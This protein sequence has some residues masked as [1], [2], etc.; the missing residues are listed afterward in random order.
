MN[1]KTKL[2]LS[3]GLLFAMIL[4]LSV[5]ASKYVY[6]LK[7]DTVNILANN[8]NSLEYARNMLTALDE[9]QGDPQA[10]KRFENELAKQKNNV[11]E[12]GEPL[13]TQ[14]VYDHFQKLKADSSDSEL[15]PLIRK[16]ISE[17]IR[18]NMYAINAKSDK[19]LHTVGE[20]I[21]LIVMTGTICFVL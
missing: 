4:M 21:L 15:Y 3:I 19:A 18:I 16:D 17:L 7:D 13:A 5:I 10:Y 8:Y 6:S 14:R 11:T 2:R 9:M 1:I 20:A 12:I